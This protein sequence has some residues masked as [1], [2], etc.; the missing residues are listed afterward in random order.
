[1]NPKK[2]GCCSICDKEIYEIILRYTQPPLER[3]PR[4]LG[5]PKDDAWKVEFALKDGSTMSLSFCEECKNK[6]TTKQFP[7]LWNR[8][9][10]SWVFEMQDDVRKVLPAKPLTTRQTE[11]LTKWFE[12]QVGN[13]MMGILASVQLKENHA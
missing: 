9:L 11:E 13:G 8:V 2:M 7:V 5:L 10:E 3:F 1:M 12:T 4:K 6:L